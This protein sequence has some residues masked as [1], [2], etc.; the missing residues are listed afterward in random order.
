MS[1]VKERPIIFSAQEVNAV[2]AGDKTQYRVIAKAEPTD[3]PDGYYYD[4]DDGEYAVFSRC[5]SAGNVDIVRVDCPFGAIGDRLWVQEQHYRHP[6][7]RYLFTT[8]PHY[9]ADGHLTLDDRHDAGLLQEYCAVDMPRWASRL[10]LEITD[11]RIERVRDIDAASAEVEG[12]FNFSGYERLK[13]RPLSAFITY[14]MAKH[15]D[16]AWFTNPWVWVIEF[17][18]IENSEVNTNAK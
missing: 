3:N 12:C 7:E 17:K 9:F 13:P 5:V 15:G 4:G 16:D 1:N 18:A 10:L 2:L 8:K 14:W 6:D 11:I